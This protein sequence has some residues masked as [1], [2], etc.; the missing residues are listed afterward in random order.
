MEIKRFNKQAGLLIILL[1]ITI[2]ITLLSL[3][4]EIGQRVF[5]YRTDGWATSTCPVGGGKNPGDIVSVDVVRKHF[6]T[7]AECLA[8]CCDGRNGRQCG[9]VLYCGQ[10]SP[11]YMTCEVPTGNDLCS[12]SVQETCGV[13]Q[14]DCTDGGG[15]DISWNCDGCPDT[16]PSP[17]PAHPT[18][19]PTLTPT[20]TK[21]PTPTPIRTPTP[22]SV[23]GY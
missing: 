7:R 20:P 18:S 6:A 23:C 21:T 19:T 4:Q 16:S 17:T 12:V 10:G 13:I 8:L 15:G 1:L 9:G 3:K 5:A 14:I 22:T 11:Y 2:P